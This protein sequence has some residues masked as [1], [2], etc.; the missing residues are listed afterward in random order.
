MS[1]RRVPRLR[2]KVSGGAVSVSKV[3]DSLEIVLVDYD[4]S[5]IRVTR[6]RLPNDDLPRILTKLAKSYVR[7][8]QR[9]LR[10]K[11][12]A[13]AQD[14]RG[15]RL[16]LADL[17]RALAQEGLLLKEQALQ[18]ESLPLSVPEWNFPA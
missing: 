5:T 2:I 18:I 14:L 13:G 6:G 17:A 12:W 15:S 1:K 9:Q 10:E 7:D 8:E 11:N 4:P 16:A 3:R